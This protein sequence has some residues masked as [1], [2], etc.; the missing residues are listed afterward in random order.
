MNSPESGIPTT[1]Y[2]DGPLLQL[3]VDAG[4]LPGEDEAELRAA[5]PRVLGR[6]DFERQIPLLT[7]F[8]VWGEVA[9]EEALEISG[10]E[11]LL[12]QNPLHPRFLED[13]K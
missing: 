12:P 13:L 3:L 9:S 5:L 6:Y 1:S 8:G 7:R 2:H 11:E 10:Q 4:D